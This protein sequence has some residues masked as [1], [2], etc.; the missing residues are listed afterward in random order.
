MPR[1]IRFIIG[2]SRLR[3][4]VARKLWYVFVFYFT[5]LT[6]IHMFM[7]VFTLLYVFYNIFFCVCFVDVVAVCCVGRRADRRVVGQ[8]RITTQQNTSLQSSFITTTT[9]TTTTTNDRFALA[10]VEVARESEFGS[11]QT[12]ITRTHLGRVLQVRVCVHE[13]SL[14]VVF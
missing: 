1:L 4:C 7:C 9:T 12:F 6:Y 14:V 5:C 11:G 2:E 10:D 3:R 8:V 13:V